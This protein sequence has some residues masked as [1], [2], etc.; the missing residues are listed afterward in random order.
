M[1]RSHDV[2]LIF[3]PKLLRGFCALMDM[4]FNFAQLIVGRMRG[5]RSSARP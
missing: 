4:K 2:M 1:R 3:R 5:L